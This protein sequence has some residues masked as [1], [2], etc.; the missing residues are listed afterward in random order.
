[1]EERERGVVLTE[2]RVDQRK[3]T[4]RVFIGSKKG[5]SHFS[6]L[7]LQP[8]EDLESLGQDVRPMYLS[9]KAC[10]RR[11]PYLDRGGR[12]GDTTAG[13]ETTVETSGGCNRTTDAL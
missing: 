2:V 11:D 7:K 3:T 12:V 9:C 6:M 1:L 5:N 8:P 13:T 4:T 10:C